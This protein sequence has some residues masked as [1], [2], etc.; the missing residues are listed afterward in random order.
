[1]FAR[2]AH[3]NGANIEDFE[4][5]LEVLQTRYGNILVYFDS[6]EC[7]R[8]I[9]HGDAERL[10]MPTG[11]TAAEHEPNEWLCLESELDNVD[12]ATRVAT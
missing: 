9:V 2:A 8:E 7:F 3:R 5:F 11:V 1:M 4:M 6:N 10:G 12:A